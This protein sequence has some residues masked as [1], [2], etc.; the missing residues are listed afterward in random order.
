MSAVAW[1]RDIGLYYRPVDCLREPEALSCTIANYFW[2][3]TDEFFDKYRI[4]ASS[5]VNCVHMCSFSQFVQAKSV[6]QS[7][8][9]LEVATSPDGRHHHHRHC[10]NR[11][12]VVISVIPVGG[13][14]TPATFSY[15]A[16]GSHNYV[17]SKLFWFAVESRWWR[18]LATS[19]R[20]ILYHY[21]Y[22]YILSS[23]ELSIFQEP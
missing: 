4:V 13:P 12:P 18:C 8:K 20:I 7:A 14:L 22:K 1:P 5:S 15:P 16:V 2:I 10:H 11:G 9:A 6:V 3:P 19:Q 23:T 21:Y 17:R